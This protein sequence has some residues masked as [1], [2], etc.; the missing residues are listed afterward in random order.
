[1]TITA[2]NSTNPRVEY[3][4]TAGQTVFDY[5]WPVFAETDLEVY[6][7]T[8]GDQPVA[9]DI[10]TLN[11]D[12]TVAGE[13]TNGGGTITLTS[14]AT[15]G[16]RLVIRHVPT[17]QRVTNYTNGGP[18]RATDR[19][20]EYN[21]VWM[22][23]KR[24]E[25]LKLDRSQE[26]TP[27]MDGD[28][29]MAMF[30]I[31]DVPDPTAG[32]DAVNRDYVLGQIGLIGNLTI[33]TVASIL[34]LR[35]LTP[36]S[37]ALVSGYYE[38]ADGGGGLFYYDSSD[39]AT[40]DNGGSVIVGNTGARWKRVP[41]VIS[42]PQQWGAVGDG[43]A[44]DTASLQAWV[45][46][47]GGFLPAGD[48]RITSSLIIIDRTRIVGPHSLW[49]NG[50]RTAAI[51]WDGP[52]NGTVVQ[53]S[54]EPV[55]TVSNSAVSGAT[56]RDFLIDGANVAGIG[57][58][59][60]YVSNGSTVDG[61]NVRACN[62]FGILAAFL[63]Y[64]HW[65]RLVARNC[66]G[67]GIAFGVQWQSSFSSTAI[68]GVTF[69][70]V[71]AANC[72]EAYDA[73]T[74]PLGYDQD[75]NPAGG[76]G[77]RL[78][79]DTSSIATGVLGE[80]CYGHGVVLEPAPSARALIDGIY[81]ENN[82]ASVVADGTG[83]ERFGMLLYSNTSSRSQYTVRG[84]YG[85]VSSNGDHVRYFA[86]TGATAAS[87]HFDEIKDIRFSSSASAGTVIPVTYSRI[88]GDLVDGG[89][90]L[91]SRQ[92]AGTSIRISNVPEA[93]GDVLRGT[94]TQLE[95]TENF[96]GWASGDTLTIAVISSRP[97]AQNRA[98]ASSV[99][100]QGNFY[101]SDGAGNPMTCESYTWLVNL[102]NCQRYSS[103]NVTSATVTELGSTVATSGG[104][105]LSVATPTVVWDTTDVLNVTATIQVVPTS[106]ATVAA[107]NS[108]SFAVSMMGGGL[109]NGATP[110]IL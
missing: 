19:N 66:A 7:S 37:Y 73:S 74:A 94:S 59:G 25:A 29:S 63:F 81:V 50:T 90:G 34:Q 58:F 9:A 67:I 72:G 62:Q 2:V 49:S 99:I 102:A 64:S 89:G 6:L 56:L 46:S 104:D 24:L 20:D 12:Y 10:L 65:R 17:L 82:M 35:A 57:L 84:F 39:V 79:L 78:R 106:T 21:K 77:V 48:Y 27:T 41:S 93:P 109:K 61:I 15:A 110:S 30:S 54:K 5:D 76:C 98:V 45:G 92:V 3:V 38:P 88:I 69:E 75:D 71:R 95:T 23:I 55:G 18:D 28:L 51:I 70:D 86:E 44:D 103:G 14:A 13:E 26:D 68:N 8:S 16:D 80:S 85:Q 42:S 1:M 91:I 43:V 36:T 22:A 97:Q 52:A 101:V 40:A 60:N 4:A 11:T 53:M 96:E 47:G 31:T 108:A 83:T 33:P 87:W 32:A 105:K 100:V 107:N